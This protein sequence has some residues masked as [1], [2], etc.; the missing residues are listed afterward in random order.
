MRLHFYLRE[1]EMESNRRGG[2]GSSCEYYAPVAGNMRLLL[3]YFSVGCKF[4]NRF[5]PQK[6]Q[7]CNHLDQ[8]S[9]KQATVTANNASQHSTF[10]PKKDHITLRRMKRRCKGI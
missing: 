5:F 1:T 7:T 10:K 4:K 8:R 6:Q 2:A 9:R 3:L